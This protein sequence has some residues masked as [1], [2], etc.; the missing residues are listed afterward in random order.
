VNSVAIIG[1]A[2]F[3]GRNIAATLHAR[4]QTVRVLARAEC[5]L[6]AFD[7]ARA[8]KALNGADC[9]VN[10]AGVL[11]GKKRKPLDV[12][13]ARGTA[14]LLDACR[15]AGVK[16]LIHLSALGA[17]AQG[18]T[19]YQRSK[20]RG[21]AILDAERGL[22]ICII[23]PSIVIGRGGA[24]TAL[25]GAMAALPIVPRLSLHS[26]AVQPIMVDDLSDIV[27]RLIESEG[28]LPRTLDAVGPECM[29]IDEVIDAIG[30]WL[31]LP[32]RNCVNLPG[33][34]TAGLVRAGE[35][36]RLGPVNRETLVMLRAGNVSNQAPI[37]AVLGHAP[38]P[39]SQALGRH[40]ASPAD[41]LQARLYFVQ[42]LLRVSLAILWVA[43]GLLSFGLY[44]A[45]KSFALMRE[46][47]LDGRPASLALYGGACLDLLL[48]LLL[49]AG[50]QPK[51]VGAAML[52]SM[53]VF[54]AL[55]LR[56]PAD[57]WMHPFAPLLKNLPIAAAILAM[58]AME[59]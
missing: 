41:R 35:C 4:G 19:D 23:R 17:D 18:Q 37:A 51:T 45:E 54:S 14:L 2:G 58:V 16:R 33:W 29:P 59:A 30:V 28:K 47:G 15:R 53:A 26:G 46:V 13:H 57:F 52:A 48:G 31:G 32:K 8:A 44:P 11:R 56:L 43:T 40:P 12:I 3:I 1:G 36:L 24:S 22:D 9:V 42:P 21:E 25:F 27:A 39:V 6:T 50:R 20:G 38:S 49:L 5:D 55:A 34:V 7:A 10:C